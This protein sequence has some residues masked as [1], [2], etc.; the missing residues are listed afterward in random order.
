MSSITVDSKYRIVLEK[1]VR[2]AAGIKKRE[3]LVAEPFKGGVILMSS[4]GRSFVDS[5][6]GF[7]FREEKH[8]A[9][10]YLLG[11]KKGAHT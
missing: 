4:N 10:R 11:E 7:R 3:R 5:L 1:K 2:T 9:D 8:Q 6:R